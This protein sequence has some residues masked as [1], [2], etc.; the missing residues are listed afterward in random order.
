M[1]SVFLQYI[2]RSNRDNDQ[3]VYMIP[4]IRDLLAR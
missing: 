4:E 3:G 2:D 1:R